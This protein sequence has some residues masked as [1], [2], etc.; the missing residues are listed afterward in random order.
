MN[1]MGQP[2]VE[3]DFRLTCLNGFGDG[4]NHYAHSMAW[5]RGRLY[6]GTTR[7]SMAGLKLSVPLPDIKPWPID[8]PMD[9]YAIPRQAEIWEYTPETAT[10][11]LAFRSPTVTGVNGRKGVPSYVSYR[12]MTVFQA[13]QDQA[14]C[15]YVATWSTHLAHSPDLLRSEDG[16][17]FRPVKRPPFGPTV[18][19]FRT[20]QPFNGR[21]H[22]SATAMGTAKGFN[23]DFAS[24]AVIYAADDL[25][26]DTW[27]ATSPDGFGNR[28]NSTVF[29]MEVFD[30]HLY[31]GTANARTGGELWKT[32]GGTPPYQWSKVFDRGAERGLH[33]EVAGS[34]CEFKGALY[35]GLGVVNGGFHRAAKIG[36][37]AAEI[38]RVWPDDSWDL[39]VGES[40]MTSQGL[41]YPLSGFSPGFDNIFNGYVWRMKEHDGWLYASTMTWAGLMPYLPMEV[42]PPDILALLD[43]WGIERL[44]ESGGF[45]LWRTPDGVHWEPVTRDGFGNKFNWGGRTFASTPHGL[46]VGTANPFGPTVAVR[47]KGDWQYVHNPRGGCEVWLGAKQHHDPVAPP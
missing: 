30:G 28:A 32:R 22:L 35:V 9:V 41:K 24:E 31:G 15:L 16:Q 27:C 25:E 39:I 17:E 44:A 36:P 33:N 38:I 10:W 42:W 14:P 45:E 43:R 23:Q 26:G 29:E 34:M 11:R 46:F 8:S 18:R 20:L 1:E 37:A 3:T 19:S 5:F 6:V 2:L 47:R 21:V 13:A 7:A 12:G 40:R 4:W